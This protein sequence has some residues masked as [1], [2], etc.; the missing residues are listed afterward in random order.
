MSSDFRLFTNSDTT[1]VRNEKVGM[2]VIPEKSES[3]TE[4]A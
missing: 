4:K 2:G 3:Y 1:R